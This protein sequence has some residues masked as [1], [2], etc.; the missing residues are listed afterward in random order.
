MDIKKSTSLWSK[1]KG[2]AEHVNRIIN[3][4]FEDCVDVIENH[5]GAIN[6]YVGDEI[7]AF[8]NAYKSDKEHL[9]H[10]LQCAKDIRNKYFSD[11]TK[12]INKYLKEIGKFA[13]T[14]YK[15]PEGFGL[16][17]GITVTSKNETLLGL[18]GSKH[19]R[20]HYTVVSEQMNAL[21]RGVSSID[22]VSITHKDLPIIYVGA[23]LDEVKQQIQSF[24]FDLN[25]IIH[26]EF[27]GLEGRDYQM[28]EILWSR[29]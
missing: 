21:A 27:R 6:V 10:S 19:K 14:K 22:K 28:A 29:K 3:I 16:R 24:D 20:H 2:S 23:K 1:V 25:E 8:F 18:V 4:I 15:T 13:P 9:K 12:K 17:M 11:T 5:E 26:C 7:L